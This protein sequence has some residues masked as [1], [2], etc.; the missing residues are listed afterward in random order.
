MFVLRMSGNLIPAASAELEIK[1]LFQNN[2]AA[3]Q[4]LYELH[5][6]SLLY[7]AFCMI[8][9]KEQAED[10]VAEVFI[11]LWN[12]RSTFTDFANIRAWLFTVTRN[13]CLNWLKHN[14]RK[15]AAQKELLYMV[16]KDEDKIHS[17]LIRAE[18]LQFIIHQVQK[19][20]PRTKKIF[21]LLFFEGLS[22]AETALKLKIT[23]DTVR[24]QK[25]RGI[26]A[27][28][29]MLNVDNQ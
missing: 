23:V 8:G 25:A 3:L 17:E 18:L 24:V 2:P 4:Y 6:T 14:R 9:N 28:R 15:T 19:L 20:P 10:I 11:R 16:E 27:L 5:H 26:H 29:K 21:E 13:D 1:E 22:T 7:F 12:K